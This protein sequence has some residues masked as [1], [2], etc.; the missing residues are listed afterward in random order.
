MATEPQN[1]NCS[2][3]QDAQSHRGLFCVAVGTDPAGRER[4]IKIKQTGKSFTMTDSRRRCRIDA[5][6]SRQLTD[7]DI[8]SEVWFV[9]RVKVNTFEFPADTQQDQ[10][11]RPRGLKGKYWKSWGRKI[12]LAQG[13]A[14]TKA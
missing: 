7:E 8:A 6:W 3:P 2:G 13:A 10:S 14:P 5:H 12:S 1:D 9:F 11:T 4:R